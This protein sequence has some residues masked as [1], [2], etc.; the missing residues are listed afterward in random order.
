MRAWLAAAAAGVSLGAAAAPDVALEVRLDPATREF[1]AVAEV[2]RPPR[3]YRF[4]PHPSLAVRNL[5]LERSGLMRIEYGGTL[6]QLDRNIDFRGVLQAL[7]PMASPEG[8]Y[9]GSAAAWYPR[10]RPFFTYRVRVS[11]P[12]A[13]KAVVPGRLLNEKTENGRYEATFEYESPADGIDLMAG[14]YEV[15]E[16]I[17][18]LPEKPVRLRTY[19]FPDLAGLSDAYLEDSAR[20]IER[21]SKEIGPYPFQEFSV[22][23]SPLPSGFG[24][25]SLTYIGAQVLKLPFI[26]ATSLGHEVL[27]NWWGNGVLVDYARGNWSEG[28]TTFMADYAYKEAESPQAARDMRLQW[29]RDL[30]AVPAA[31]QRPILA[32]RSRAHGA[33][34]VVGYSK[35][36]MLF[37]MLRDL[38]GEDAFA[39]GIRRFWR[40]NSFRVA[41]W[42]ELLDSFEHAS[43]R[44]LETFFEQWL[45]R[46]GAPAV[47]IASAEGGTHLRL[48]FEQANPPYALRLP[49]EFQF[50][51]GSETRWVEI[52]REKQTVTLQFKEAPR[53]VRLDPELRVWRLL[54]REELPPILRQW[55]VARSPAVLF[56]KKTPSAVKLAERLLESRFRE[57]KQPDSEPLLIIG[58]HAEVDAALE[59]LKLPPRPA[60]LAGKGSAQVWTIREA[61]KPVAVISAKDDAAL[62]A[63]ARPL[64]HYGSQSWLAFDGAR[65]IERGAWPPLARSVPVTGQIEK[66]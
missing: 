23:A 36:A 41:S 59:R 20:Y 57:V 30:A 22:V 48:S 10:P 54:E 33:D 52:E 29:L 50:E 25:P 61:E 38:V 17:L 35:S 49:V 11:L 18:R 42:V 2:W 40:E 26:R 13:Q 27:H 64:P 24:M 31:A 7:P 21:Y 1:S 32:F 46:A 53:A 39:L 28:L 44:N 5:V 58:P 37:F 55:I 34:A 16:R 15:R 45:V 43:G 12:A 9:L 63:L 47:R 56:P 3:D 19:F 51:K 66:N 6:P 4:T 65:V 62:E 14:P 8:S 60:M